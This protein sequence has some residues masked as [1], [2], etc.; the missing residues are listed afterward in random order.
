MGFLPQLPGKLCH[1]EAS[2]PL[3]HSKLDGEPIL[4]LRGG[5]KK[6]N[7]LVCGILKD[8]FPVSS[9][10]G[11]GLEKLAGCQKAAGE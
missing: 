10:S 11:S 8:G 5:G 3:T 6:R 1:E 9:A 7:S 2:D 4:L